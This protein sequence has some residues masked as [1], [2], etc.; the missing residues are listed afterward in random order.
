MKK[1]SW[2]FALILAL[3]LAFIGCPAPDDDSPS[4]GS[5]PGGSTGGG[6]EG[7]IEFG[8][9]KVEV[10]KNG[11][12]NGDIDPGTLGYV[13][14]GFH[15]TYGKGGNSADT[16]WNFGN[17]ILRFQITLDDGKT[18][19]D[20]GFVTFN[21]QA[22]GPYKTDVNTNKKLYLLASAN[23]DDLTPYK[24]DAKA[25]DDP[26]G[27]RYSIVSSTYFDEGHTGD[28]NK[29]WSDTSS[30]SVNGLEKVKIQLPIKKKGMLGG[31]IWFAIYVHANGGGYTITNFKLGG[32]PSYTNPGPGTA[33]PDEPPVIVPGE[34]KSFDLDLTNIVTTSA[35]GTPL[36]S[37]TASGSAA[38]VAFTASDQRVVFGLTEAQYGIINSRVDNR[39]TINVDA[40]IV[41]NG[42]PSGD[43]FRYHI[44]DASA[45]GNWNT[46]NPG[47]NNT[48]LAGLI[49]AKDLQLNEDSKENDNVYSSRPKHF[50]L[51]HRNANAITIKI[52]RVTITVYVEESAPDAYLEANAK[53]KEASADADF[54]GFYGD[55]THSIKNNIMTIKGHGGFYVALPNSVTASDSVDITY[56][57]YL[58]SGS[59]KFIRKQKDGWSDVTGDNDYKYNS[60]NVPDVVKTITVDLS[61]FNAEGVAAKKAFFQTDGTFEARMKIIS[62]VKQGGGA[63]PVTNVNYTGPNSGFVGVPIQLAGAVQPSDAEHKVIAWTVDSSSTATATIDASNKL[64]ATTE[65]NVTLIATITNGLLTSD[66]TKTFTDAITIS[67]LG[68]ETL[69]NVAIAGVAGV[70]DTT[71]KVAVSGDPA[72]VGGGLVAVTNGYKFNCTKGYGNSNVIFSVDLGTKTLGDF[73]KV[74]INFVGVS[75]DYGSKNLFLLAADNE[76]AVTMWKSDDA[77]KALI[78]NS[79][80]ADTSKALYD[81][82]WAV[83]STGALGAAKASKDLTI[84]AHQDLTGTVWF[85]IYIHGNPYSVTI[86]SITFVEPE[87]EE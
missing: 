29:I 69:A 38:N 85:S 81:G 2:I 53:E 4:G 46:T 12:N 20:Y 47:V 24:D 71:V 64:T 32:D 6:D 41:T 14:G 5:K 70:T 7:G 59:G 48:D 27:I 63:E 1:F 45:G 83:A 13:T 43:Q 52:N 51:Q 86:D 10:K 55:G 25:P 23:E 19:D 35:I 62:V 30:P 44:G 61:T 82:A 84:K 80:N 18:L 72:T 28:D 87:E 34:A 33:A 54:I 36:A 77:I 39:V 26:D 17:S 40:E 76:A 66:F 67:E 15:Y 21:W 3:S 11:T 79:D 73:T 22:D 8:A 60:F 9:G 42:D 75:G 68:T 58:V 56:I 65:G 37:V 16:N 57:Y 50:I 31:P 74:T 49:G 78:A